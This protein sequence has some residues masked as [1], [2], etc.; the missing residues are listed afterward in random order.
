METEHG[1][2]GLGSSAKKPPLSNLGK[3]LCSNTANQSAQ[4]LADKIYVHADGHIGL[5]K[6]RLDYIHTKT[7]LDAV[8]AKRDQLPD[9][10]VTIFD[11]GLEHMQDQPAGQGKIAV[12]AIAAASFEAHDDVRPAIPSIRTMLRSMDAIET[13]SGE[14]IIGA[15]RGF[16]LASNTEPRELMAFHPSFLYYIGQ[17]YNKTIHR[18]SLEIKTRR[19]RLGSQDMPELPSDMSPN[20]LVQSPPMQATEEE[21]VRRFIVRKGTQAWQ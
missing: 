6:A 15:T 21:P 20:K 1:D 17:R 14:D 2:L 9:N 7:S 8:E 18:A 11:S 19:P 5:A 3:S 13:R 10:I 16:L 4:K 12:R